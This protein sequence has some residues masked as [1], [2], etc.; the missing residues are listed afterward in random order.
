[1][2]EPHSISNF[3]IKEVIEEEKKMSSSESEL[4]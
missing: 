2:I 4:I 3:E 1:M